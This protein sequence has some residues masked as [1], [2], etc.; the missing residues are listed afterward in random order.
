LWSWPL[1]PKTP[2]LRRRKAS[3]TTRDKDKITDMGG[4][5]MGVTDRQFAGFLRFI[6]DALI[7]VKDEKDPEKKEK[8][9]RV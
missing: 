2:E 8:S 3:L 5:A 6:I 9:W 1:P 7:E 4:K